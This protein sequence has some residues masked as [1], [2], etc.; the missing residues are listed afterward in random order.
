MF[1]IGWLAGRL[2]R[3]LAVKRYWCV[4]CQMECFDVKVARLPQRHHVGLCVRCET[5]RP[6]EV[7]T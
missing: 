2:T 6:V 1:L 3:A 5:W 4:S 7:T